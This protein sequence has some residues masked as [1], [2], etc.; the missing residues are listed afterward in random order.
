[1]RRKL[2]KN[3][4]ELSALSAGM[5]RLNEWE[6]NVAERISYIEFCLEAGV[7]T[8][9]HADI[10]GDYKNEAL[11][12][13]ALKER[14]DLRNKMEIVTKCGICLPVKDRPENKLQHYNTSAAH[15]RKSVENSL[16][17]LGTDYLD[18]VLIHRPDP[19]MDAEE[20]A[21]IFMK[22]YEEGKVNHVGVSNFTTH[23]FDLFQKKLDL[24]LVTNQVECS[25]I[26]TKPIYD[27]T[28]DQAQKMEI[29]PML[30]SPLAGGRLFTGHGEQSQR[31]LYVCDELCEKYDSSVDQIALAWLLHLPCNPLPVMGTGKTERVN[32]AIKA[33]NI[34][35]DRQD[36]YKLLE[37]SNGQPVP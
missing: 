25:L 4:P 29:S 11:F 9:D 21:D 5:W 28:F 10:Y 33:L 20:M 34:N 23:Q 7:T 16:R 18:L 22:L 32:S 36:W 6:M 15:I 30:W 37:A 12:G 24:T 1:M 8:F 13:E 31:V 2:H 17:N 3:G 35:L 19:L 26:H 14:P 27:G